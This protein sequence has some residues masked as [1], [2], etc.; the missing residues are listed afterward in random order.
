MLESESYWNNAL[1]VARGDYLLLRTQYTYPCLQTTPSRSLGFFALLENQANA[2]ESGSG[3][4]VLRNGQSHHDSAC[5][6]H[7]TAHTPSSSLVVV[8]TSLARVDVLGLT[9]TSVT[10][11]VC[12]FSNVGVVHTIVFFLFLFLCVY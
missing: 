1:G 6:G 4:P 2:E 10:N 7:V 12:R 8:S 3:G 5:A 11:E 9:Q